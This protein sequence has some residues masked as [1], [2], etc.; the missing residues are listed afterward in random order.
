VPP[1]HPLARADVSDVAT[2][3]VT[4]V[5]FGVMEAIFGKRAH[6]ELLV[7]R[8]GYVRAGV[9]VPTRWGGTALAEEPSILPPPNEHVD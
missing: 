9:R 3:R 2:S 8:F 7:D 4:I 6:L 5:T 1:L